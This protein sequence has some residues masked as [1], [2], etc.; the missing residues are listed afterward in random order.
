MHD[1]SHKC[2]VKIWLF[3][4]VHVHLVAFLTQMH[5]NVLEYKHMLHDM[6]N[7]KNL[8]WKINMKR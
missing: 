6:V 7:R 2:H 1:L 4:V 5:D 3:V 8:F